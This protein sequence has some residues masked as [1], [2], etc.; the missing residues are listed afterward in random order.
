ML[1]R[2]G[3]QFP[4]EVPQTSPASRSVDFLPSGASR[5]SR[6]HTVESLWPW[7]GARGVYQGPLESAARRAARW[8]PAQISFRRPQTLAGD[9]LTVKSSKL[10][11][12]RAALRIESAGRFFPLCGP[13]PSPVA[14]SVPRS[15][16]SRRE[17]RDHSAPFDRWSRPL[18]KSHASH[19]CSAII[20]RR[21]LQWQ[22]AGR[23]RI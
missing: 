8:S 9:F 11:L 18:A 20:L 15:S 13:R 10:L 19:L 23:T 2:A 7:R 21:L 6:E 5:C 4:A 22:T 12:K 14:R 3:Y 1:D 16:R 17:K